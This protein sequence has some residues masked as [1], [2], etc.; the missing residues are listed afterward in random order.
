MPRSRTDDHSGGDA[1]T[2]YADE[3][4]PSGHHARSHDVR[5]EE[6]TRPKG[7]RHEEDDFDRDLTSG[8]SSG[9][10]L[11]DRVLALDDDKSLRKGIA[12]LDSE[13]VKS[14]TILT[15]GTP[16]DQGSVYVDLN[17][18]ERGSFK[19]RGDEQAGPDNRY[20]AKRDLDY[21]TWDRLIGRPTV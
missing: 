16:L 7:H 4:G 3:G 15:V 6:A 21:E 11:E 10:H 8:R 2:P 12:G 1:R 20:V 19:A 5:A 13:Q 18:L 17:Q 14:L 9:D